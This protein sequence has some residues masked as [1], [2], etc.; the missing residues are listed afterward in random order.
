[1]SLYINKTTDNPIIKTNLSHIESRKQRDGETN[2]DYEKRI[3]N[4]D[5]AKL[6]RFNFA[7]ASAKLSKKLNKVLIKSEADINKDS[8][9][10]KVITQPDTPMKTPN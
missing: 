6:K 4:L 1:M 3:N 2:I 10:Q 9:A 5:K 8:L 7:N